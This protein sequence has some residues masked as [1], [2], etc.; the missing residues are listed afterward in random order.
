MVCNCNCRYIESATPHVTLMNVMSNEA[1]GI[2]AAVAAAQEA[3]V[4]ND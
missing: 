1:K 4:G 2:A 3:E